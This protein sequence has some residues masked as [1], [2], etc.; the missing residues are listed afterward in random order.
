MADKK[1]KSD[2]PRHTVRLPG[3][4]T[5]RIDELQKLFQCNKSVIFRMGIDALLEQ[6]RAMEF[7]GA[8]AFDGDAETVAKKWAVFEALRCGKGIVMSAREAKTTPRTVRDWLQNDPNFLEWAQDAKDESVEMAEYVVH[9]KA[10]NE[11]HLGAAFGV[12][13][14]KHSQYGMV[15]A[16]FV[17]AKIKKF[18]KD[19][20]LPLVAKYLSRDQLGKFAG[21]LRQRTPD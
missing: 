12:L 9:H 7:V 19:V 3:E 13:N 14:A 17:V 2:Y 5:E 4:Y 20:V 18:N 11:N 16:G 21:E 6:N 10:V 8:V 15:K 1:N